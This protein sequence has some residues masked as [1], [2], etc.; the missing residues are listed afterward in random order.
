[1]AKEKKP[2]TLVTVIRIY[3]RTLKGDKKARLTVGLGFVLPIVGG[4]VA[5]N[6]LGAGNV[7]G[8][9]TWYVT[10]VLAALLASMILL[11]RPAE[12]MQLAQFESTPGATTLILKSLLKRSFRGTEEPVGVNPRSQEMVF[13]MVGAPG[14]VVLAEGNRNSVR[15]LVEEQRRIAQKVANGV[16]FHVVYVGKDEHQVPLINLSRY[17][18]KLKRV[19]N[20]REIRETHNRLSSMGL[21]LPLPKGIDPM[22]VRMPRR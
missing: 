5:A 2:N 8:Q 19:L 17:V 10:G 14:I 21:R 6:T 15:N 18:L 22:R 13:R 4:S 12:R 9:I 20:R 11:S 7:F 3:G 16:P 1:M